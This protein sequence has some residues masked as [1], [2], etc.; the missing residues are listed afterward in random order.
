MD[1]DSNYPSDYFFSPES[2]EF[3]QAPMA[4]YVR[5]YR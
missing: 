1:S 4:P 3:Y 2:S 5:K